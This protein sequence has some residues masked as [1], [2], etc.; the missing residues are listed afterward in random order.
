MSGFAATA[1]SLETLL[2]EELVDSLTM[3]L[4]LEGLAHHVELLTRLA[5][6]EPITLARH[7]ALVALQDREDWP[8]EEGD[9]LPSRF[10]ADEFLRALCDAAGDGPDRDPAF[11]AR[12]ELESLRAD[13]IHLAHV[14]SHHLADMKKTAAANARSR[15]L[16]NRSHVP[17]SAAPGQGLNDSTAA[18]RKER[19]LRLLIDAR[20]EHVHAYGGL[21]FEPIRREDQADLETTKMIWEAS[22]GPCPILPEYDS[23][24]PCW[25]TSKAAILER[26]KQNQYCGKYKAYPE[27]GMPPT[28][29]LL[30]EFCCVMRGAAIAWTFGPESKDAAGELIR[31]HVTYSDLDRVGYGVSP[32]TYVTCAAR[33]PLVEQLVADL[34]KRCLTRGSTPRQTFELIRRIYSDLS[35][36]LTNGGKV[37]TLTHAIISLRTQR[38][39][40]LF[41]MSSQGPSYTP[42]RASGSSSSRSNKSPARTSRDSSRTRAVPDSRHTKSRASRTESKRVRFDSRTDDEA[43]GAESRDA[44]PERSRASTSSDNGSRGVCFAWRDHGRCSHGANCRFE[45]SN[46]DKG[47]KQR[48]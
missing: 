20:V 19:R 46:N 43:S 30:L 26:N 22:A 9:D 45:H 33:W 1:P 25:A 4:S 11:P 44:S 2:K 34:T 23:L 16:N 48:S 40:G 47:P 13:I 31:P 17:S 32:D 10:A 29:L 27:S 6:L 12:N 37:I 39:E 18:E 3:T 38:G 42:S 41:D 14:V 35:S 7:H 8:E 24:T 21:S 36:R 15:H 28:S 5:L